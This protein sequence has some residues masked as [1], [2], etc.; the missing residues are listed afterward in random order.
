MNQQNLILKVLEDFK[1]ENK[2][3]HEQIIKRLD[4]TNG[5]VVKNTEFRIQSSA[6]IAFLKWG[7]AIIGVSNISSILYLYFS[8]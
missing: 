3:G 5:N 2:E 7:I 8:R 4:I 6:V 1:M